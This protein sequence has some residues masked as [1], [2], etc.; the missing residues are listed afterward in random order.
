MGC[1]FR[2]ALFLLLIAVPVFAG[3]HEHASS[4]IDGS[5]HPELVSDTD[6]HRHLF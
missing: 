6:A 5:Q 4:V 2:L 3:D 1:V